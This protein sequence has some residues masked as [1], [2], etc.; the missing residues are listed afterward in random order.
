LR[1][2]TPAQQEALFLFADEEPDRVCHRIVTRSSLASSVIGA[3]RYRQVAQA[4]CKLVDETNKLPTRIGE[5]SLETLFTRTLR[6]RARL[7]QTGSACPSWPYYEGSHRTIREKRSTI[8][9]G[10][11]AMAHRS[12]TCRHTCS[13]SWTIRATVICW[14]SRST[15]LID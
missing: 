8:H 12:Q 5:S 4:L 10:M 15:G 11:Y 7:Q 3:S 14:P 6:V 1:D 2:L 13:G 9:I